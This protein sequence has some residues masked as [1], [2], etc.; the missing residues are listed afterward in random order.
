MPKSIIISRH[1]GPEVLEIK[2]VKIGS[3]GPN[4]IK[5]KNTTSLSIEIFLGYAQRSLHLW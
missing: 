3:P 1:G 2:D 5:V 4:E